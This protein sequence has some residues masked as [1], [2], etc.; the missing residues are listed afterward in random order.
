V[1]VRF[2]GGMK[3]QRTWFASDKTGFHMLHTLFQTSLKYPSI[4]RYDEFFCADLIEE[5]GRVQGVVAIDIASG[6]FYL[7]ECK[8]AIICT[9]GAGRAF[10][11]NTNAGIVTGDGMGMAY[12]HGVPLRDMEFIQYHPT[13]LPG[14]G[15]MITEGCRGEGGI[16]NNKDGY[17][18]LQD[19]GRG[20]PDPSPRPKAMELGPGSGCRRR[21]GT[22]SRRGARRARPR[23]MPCGSTCAT[24]APPGSTNAAAHH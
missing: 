5:D 14:T 2:F 22:R 20:P 16:L 17:R 18:Y 21:S 4:K 1:N 19:Y 12:R 23:A 7:I 24:S 11:Q 3:V 8:A 10:G 9:G 6:E 15:V 13:A